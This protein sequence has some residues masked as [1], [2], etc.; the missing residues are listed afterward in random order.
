M[1]T[2]TK[3][4]IGYTV[5]RKKKRFLLKTDT[6]GKDGHFIMIK[7]GLYQEDIIIIYAPN[8]TTEKCMEEKKTDRIEERNRQFNN[9]CYTL[10]I[11]FQ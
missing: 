6:R 3:E 9:N 11:H 7:R 10:L 1:Q 5:L 8:K 2:S 4:I